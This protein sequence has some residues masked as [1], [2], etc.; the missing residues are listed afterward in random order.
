VGKTLIE[1]LELIPASILTGQRLV[2]L[3]LMKLS[4]FSRTGVVGVQ[5]Q[6]RL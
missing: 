5:E 1:L 2:K 6:A 3:M 4:P